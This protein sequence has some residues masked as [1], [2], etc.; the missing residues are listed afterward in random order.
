MREGSHYLAGGQV[1]DD[2][3]VILVEDSFHVVLLPHSRVLIQ[4]LCIFEG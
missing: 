3:D 4:S 1:H 2:E